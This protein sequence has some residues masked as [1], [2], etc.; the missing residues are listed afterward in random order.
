M[1]TA[2]KARAKAPAKPKVPAKPKAGTRGAKATAKKTA[3]SGAAAKKANAAADRAKK[4]GAAKARGTSAQLA[5]RNS[6]IL[7]RVAQGIAS[8]EIAKEFGV[9]AR[10]VQRVVKDGAKLRSPLDERPMELLRAIAAGYTRS[11]G[12]YEGMAFAWV[13]TNQSASLGA[14]KAADETRARLA[15]LLVEVGKLPTDLELFRSEMQMQRIA[16][17]M[18]GMMRRVAAGEADA[19]EAVDYFRTLISSQQA[20]PA[21]T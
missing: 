1:A 17:E 11:I 15:T 9:D 3:T 21:G 2:R 20:L 8:V 7:A 5:L 16:E 4:A 10:T 18:V 6:A 13:D 14:K 19:S 12:D